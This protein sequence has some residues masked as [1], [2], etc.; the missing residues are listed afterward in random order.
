MTES[1]NFARSELAGITA[2]HVREADGQ[3]WPSDLS[4]GSQVIF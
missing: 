4:L 2:V 3:K 1:E